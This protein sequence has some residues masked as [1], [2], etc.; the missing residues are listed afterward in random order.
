MFTIAPSRKSCIL[1]KLVTQ[2]PMT[3]RSRAWVTLTGQR[4]AQPRQPGAWMPC[5]TGRVRPVRAGPRSATPRGRTPRN[6]TAASLRCRPARDARGAG[7]RR[8]RICGSG[9]ERSS[10]RVGSSRI[11]PSRSPRFAAPMTPARPVDVVPR[12]LARISRRRL[13]PR[14]HRGC[15]GATRAPW[16]RRMPPGLLPLPSASAGFRPSPRAIRT[17]TI[18]ARPSRGVLRTG[19]ARRRSRSLPGGL[20]CTST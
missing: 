18:A 4:R 17:S 20:R 7:I 14:P 16:R 6:S 11:R 5:R 12:P 8:S 10:T 2:S 9:R 3:S 13:R 1:C 19:R 15:G